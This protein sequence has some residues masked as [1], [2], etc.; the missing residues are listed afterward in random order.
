MNK[1][2]KRIG[3]SRKVGQNARVHVKI[4]NMW[5][6]WI[7]V[8]NYVLE[9]EMHVCVHVKICNMWLCWI[10]VATCVLEL[11]CLCVFM[12]I[13][14]MRLCWIVV[15]MVVKLVSWLIKS[16]DLWVNTDISCEIG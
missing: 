1:T 4:C 16:Y 10:V 5:L 2:W 13:Y 15:T 9:L 6:Y 3:P 11:Q 7:V 12:L 8:T 14:N